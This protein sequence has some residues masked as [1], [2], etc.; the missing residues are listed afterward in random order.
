MP[1]DYVKTCHIRRESRSEYIEMASLY[2]NT[3][4]ELENHPLP[5]CFFAIFLDFYTALSYKKCSAEYEKPNEKRV[6]LKLL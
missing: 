6:K 3:T 1:N 2:R 4:G 5:Y